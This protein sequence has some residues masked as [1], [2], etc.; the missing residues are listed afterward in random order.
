MGPTVLKKDTDRQVDGPTQKKSCE[1]YF[2]FFFQIS[3]MYTR[4]KVGILLFLND[5]WHESSGSAL[6]QNEI[7]YFSYSDT[8]SKVYKFLF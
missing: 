5:G 2:T 6:P 3:K 7:F 4:T 8:I 1:N